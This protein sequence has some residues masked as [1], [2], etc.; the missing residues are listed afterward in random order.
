MLLEF[1]FLWEDHLRKINI[2]HHMI[3]LSPEARPIH[4]TPYRAGP[5]AGLLKWNEITETREL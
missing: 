3:R 2:A 1:E 4:S 5:E